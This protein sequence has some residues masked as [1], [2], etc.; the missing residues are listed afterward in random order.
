MKNSNFNQLVKESEV[1]YDG[2]LAYIKIE[3]GNTL[4]DVYMWNDDEELQIEE[5]N[6]YLTDLKKRTLE[7]KINNYIKEYEEEQEEERS[8]F[9]SEDYAHFESLIF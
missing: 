3:D 9:T 6:I 4:I 5:S 2:D 8:A 1:V 7:N